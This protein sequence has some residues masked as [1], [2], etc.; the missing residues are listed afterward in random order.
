MLTLIE[1]FDDNTHKCYPFAAV[2]NL[3]TDFL[4]DA[5]FVTTSNIDKD[6]LYISSVAIDAAYV[7]I[8]LAYS[9]KDS[10][11]LIELG[12]ILDCAISN[13]RN[14]EHVIKLINDENEVIIEGS[15]TIGSF[16]T[17]S[18]MPIGVYNLGTKGR[19]FSQC[20]IPVTEWCTGLV[21]NGRLY[22]G[23]VELNFDAGFT[24]TTD[25]ETNII[26]I[27]AEAF[28]LPDGNLD[29]ISEEEMQ[30]IAASRL[31]EGVTSINGCTGEVSIS[32]GSSVAPHHTY[33]IDDNP[34]NAVTDKNTLSV[35]TSGNAI[36][37]ENNKDDP[38][39]DINAGSGTDDSGLATLLE[40]AKA[41]NNR[42]GG[43]EQ[44]N[45]AVDAAVGLLST[46]MSKVT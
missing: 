33:N 28:S 26:T 22:T 2:N 23:I 25:Y 38:N 40:N 30:E 35:T 32:A 27:G 44:H 12:T 8:D 21:I 13:E 10:T 45:F 46:Q 18:S 1:F 43:I 9:I 36:I 39:Y 41:L 34:S 6:N 5:H 19:L 31:G 20:V 4:V 15:I 24:V 16:E 11:E 42:A 3:P 14:I 29:T 7:R 17:I 37:L